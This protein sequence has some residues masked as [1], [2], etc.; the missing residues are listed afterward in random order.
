MA[1]TSIWSV[2]GW[3]GK[4]LIYAENPEKTLN[5]NFYPRKDL[6]EQ[7]RQGLDDVIDYAVQQGKTTKIDTDDEN[8]S[9]IQRFV[10]GVNCSASTA[11]DEMIAVKRRF[12]KENGVVAYHGYQSFA[13]GEVNPQT[14]HEIGLKLAQKLWGNGYQVIVATHLDQESHIHNHFVVNTVSFKD[15]KRYHR[16]EKDYYDM[17]KESDRLCREYGLS[18]IE[19]PQRGKS[20]H[21]GEWKAEQDSRPTWRG[22]IRAD[23]DSAIR[24]SK[25]EKQFFHFLKEMGYEIKIGRD[26]SVRPLGKERFFRLARNLGEE[27]SIGEIRR[28]ILSQRFLKLSVSSYV[29]HPPKYT[30]RVSFKKIRKVTGFRALYFHYCYLLGIFPKKRPLKKRSVPI[31]FREDLIRAKELSDE[32][33]L[34]VK[35]RIDTSEQLLD[36]QSKTESE[37]D[38]ITSQRKQLYKV[39]RSKNTVQDG[40]IKMEVKEKISAFNAELKKLRYQVKLCKDIIVRSEQIKEK[41]KTIH[42]DAENQRKERE[43]DEQFR[44][45]G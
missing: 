12:G 28:R 10:S 42:E 4:L 26:I 27:Y 36:F 40:E 44:G 5:P 31:L 21:Y 13:P 43:K 41:F 16:T 34:L 3:L 19:N 11:R 7:E 18:V 14:A 30:L 9:V 24:R 8:V 17:Q 35:H 25:T 2:K 15:G 29:S 1:T 20:K 23:M 33:R 32:A 38:E 39:L 45:R 22:I 37:I 6:S